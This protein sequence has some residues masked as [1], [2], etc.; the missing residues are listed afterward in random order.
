VPRCG[1]IVS[2][3]SLIKSSTPFF[4]PLSPPLS[5]A[6]ATRIASLAFFRLEMYIS[7]FSSLAFA[8][9]AHFS[10]ALNL[11]RIDSNRSRGV[12]EEGAETGVGR[13]LTSFESRYFSNAEFAVSNNSGVRW[14][15]FSRV[16][17]MRYDSLA[18]MIIWYQFGPA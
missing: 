16:C 4:P 11:V 3:L 13:H 5:C 6:S 7:N 10:S 17:L 1:P 12:E 14:A 9:A 8:S 15:F 2:A 18:R